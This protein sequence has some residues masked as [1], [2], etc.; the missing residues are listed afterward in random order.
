MIALKKARKLIENQPESEAAR[1]LSALVVALESDMPF[2]VGDI[3]KLDY[4]AFELALDVLK[5]W[6]LDRYYTS[7]VRMLDLAV[8]LTEQPNPAAAGQPA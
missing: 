2:H 4:D 6:R 8:Q 1:T 7:K 5:E 3:Y